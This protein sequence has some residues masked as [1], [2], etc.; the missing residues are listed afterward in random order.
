[1]MVIYFRGII[2]SNVEDMTNNSEL[3]DGNINH[4][5]NIA[6]SYRY[7]IIVSIAIY[8]CIIDQV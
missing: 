5:P 2:L 1:M 3:N 4:N 6:A 7:D 8:V